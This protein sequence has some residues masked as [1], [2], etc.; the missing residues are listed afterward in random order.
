MALPLIAGAAGLAGLSALGGAASS[1]GQALAEGLKPRPQEEKQ[2]ME[3]TTPQRDDAL[4]PLT[5]KHLS[6]KERK[7]AFKLANRRFWRNTAME[8]VGRA[9]DLI[10]AQPFLGLVAGVVL[11]ESLEKAK[12][13]NRGT[14]FGLQT[15]GMVS[16]AAPAGGIGVGAALGV[17]VLSETGLPSKDQVIDAVGD[18]AQMLPTGPIEVLPGGWDEKLNPFLRGYKWAQNRFGWGD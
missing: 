10:R 4:D 1:A 5:L 8:G 14:A 15:M 6:K 3:F 11:V 13:I 17:S 2:P 12:V 18:Y 16:A 9:A 7:E